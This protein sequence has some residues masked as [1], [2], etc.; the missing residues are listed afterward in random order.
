MADEILG[1]DGKPVVRA[2]YFMALMENVENEEFKRTTL[3]VIGVF[4]CQGGDLP[5]EVK[6]A[7]NTPNFYLLE[8]NDSINTLLETKALIANVCKETKNES[9]YR[10]FTENFGKRLKSNDEHCE[11]ILGGTS[12]IGDNSVN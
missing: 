5:P 1:L 2:V 12:S 3:K 9:N 10:V 6:K 8:V 4:A 7:L 11:E